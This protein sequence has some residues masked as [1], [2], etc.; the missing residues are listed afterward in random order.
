MFFS[1]PNERESHESS[2][3]FSAQRDLGK[4]INCTNYLMGIWLAAAVKGIFLLAKIFLVQ[5][6]GRKRF[7]TTRFPVSD[8]SL[9]TLN[10]LREIT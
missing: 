1:G 9:K 3:V 8:K 10:Q 6:D 4:V 7:I 2:Q 5:R